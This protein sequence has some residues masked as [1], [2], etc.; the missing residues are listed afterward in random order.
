MNYETLKTEINQPTYADIRESQ[1]YPAIAAQLNARI[2]I[3]NPSPQQQTPKRLTLA[4]IFAVIATAAPAD[5][6]KLA[7]IP[8]WIVERVET[9][10]AANDRAT[11]QNYLAIV[12]TGLSSA[13]KAAL[14]QLLAETEADPSWQATVAGQSRAEELGL[15]V[16][17]ASDVQR[18]LNM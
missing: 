1:N 10:L 16:V 11:M 18:V 8:G 2:S 4:G 6:A 5:V 3:S 15:G 7:A 12:S 9:A 13:S 17:T 14:Q